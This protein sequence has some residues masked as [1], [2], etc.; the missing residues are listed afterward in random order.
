[1]KIGAYNILLQLLNNVIGLISLPHKGQRV[2]S[3]RHPRSRRRSKTGRVD[4]GR[5]L[6][7]E[8]F[9]GDNRATSPVSSSNQDPKSENKPSLPRCIIEMNEVHEAF[10][11][12]N[13]V[14]K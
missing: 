2:A 13:S 6:G 1:M 9:A 8:L 14:L 12:F 4:D 3:F 5:E 11:Q 7:R 10:I